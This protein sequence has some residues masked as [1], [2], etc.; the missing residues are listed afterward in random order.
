[1]KC[2]LFAVDF[3]LIVHFCV[4]LRSLERKKTHVV[5]VHCFTATLV[6]NK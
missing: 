2:I 6:P 4:A 1:M 3:V 5:S